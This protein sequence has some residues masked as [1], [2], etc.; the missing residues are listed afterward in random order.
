MYNS[1]CTEIL[2]YVEKIPISIHGLIIKWTQHKGFITLAGMALVVERNHGNDS[3]RRVARIL[4]LLQLGK[5]GLL[6]T[7]LFLRA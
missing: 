5:I 3:K 7:F 6:F 2:L 1:L 4:C